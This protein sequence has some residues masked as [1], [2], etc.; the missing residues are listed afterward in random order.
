MIKRFILCLTLLTF[1]FSSAFSAS[2]FIHGQNIC[3]KN[4]ALWR[5]THGLAVP[6]FPASSF[7]WKSL[8]RSAPHYGVVGF[9]YRKGGGHVFISLGNGQ[10]LNPSARQQN[11]VKKPCSSIYPGKV[12][13]WFN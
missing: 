12:K 7:S 4:V 6:K 5:K 10:C 9:T 11:W 13:Y 3:G 1:S 2:G 8:R